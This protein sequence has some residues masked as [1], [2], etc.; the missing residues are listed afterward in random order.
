MLYS[1]LRTCEVRR[2]RLDEID[3]E[4]RRLRIEQSKGLKDRLVFLNTATVEALQTWLAR[5]GT[6]EYF[7]EHVFL[8]RHKP[9]SR[10]YCHT[11]LRTYAQRTGYRVTPHQL[12]HSCGT[13]LLN[14]GA[15]IVTVQTL[16][17]HKKIDTT[18]GYA[19]LYDGTVAADYYRAMHQV[20]S[21][22]ALP[23]DKQT[24][25]TTPGELIALVDSLHRGTLNE[26]QR[27]TL[28]LLRKGLLALTAG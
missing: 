17:G 2:L 11:R 8:F 5:R 15:P 28:Q 18:L 27:E 10:R 3:W 6:A 9:L 19:R 14:A 12:R 4:S 26:T 13:L 20:E 1:G 16:L 25:A 23:E 7:T 24:P 21:L 22:M